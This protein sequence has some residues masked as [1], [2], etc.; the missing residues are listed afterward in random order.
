MLGVLLDR[1]DRYPGHAGIRITSLDELPAAI[2][3]QG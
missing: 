1:R 3:L 2:G